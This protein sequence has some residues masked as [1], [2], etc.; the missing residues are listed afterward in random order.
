MEISDSAAC[1]IPPVLLL[2]AK[3]NKCDSAGQAP[4]AVAYEFV[5]DPTF[6]HESL[7]S[8]PSSVYRVQPFLQAKSISHM[9]AVALLPMSWML[10]L[11]V[12]PE[13]A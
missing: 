3:V 13:I 4:A 2:D 9:Y 1:M 10:V 5:D 7:P 12:P 6:R 8:E 11:S